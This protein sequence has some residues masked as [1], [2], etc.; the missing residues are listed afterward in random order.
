M[1][2]SWDD[3]SFEVSE[4]DPSSVAKQFDNDDMDDELFG[5]LGG[6]KSKSKP[7]ILQAM[8][9]SGGRGIF[10]DDD[11][12]PAVSKPAPKPAAPPAAPSPGA[13]RKGAAQ[14]TPKP[15]K[16]GGP[17]EDDLLADLLGDSDYSDISQPKE[18]V[19]QPAAPVPRISTPGSRGTG[20]RGTPKRDIIMSDEDDLLDMLDSDQER[21]PRNKPALGGGSKPNTPNITTGNL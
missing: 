15:K 14:S 4:A 19:K 13:A 10:D 21:T 8:K 7:S 9:R 1:G 11:P 2:D 12:K 16:G 3:T 6:G 5:G 20:S 18:P 17:S